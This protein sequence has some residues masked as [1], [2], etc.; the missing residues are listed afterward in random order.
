MK[1][2]SSLFGSSS[3]GSSAAVSNV[4]SSRLIRLPRC[5]SLGPSTACG[6]RS[7]YRRRPLSM[8]ISPFYSMGNS[9]RHSSS[10]AVSAS[11]F[12][13][14]GHVYGQAFRQRVKGM[15]ICESPDRAPQPVAEP[16]RGATH[17]LDPARVSGSRTRPWRTAPT[18]QPRR[19]S[20][21]RLKGW[22]CPIPS[23]G[24]SFPTE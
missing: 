14:K 20:Q 8:R 18:P 3:N 11:R 17:R 23:Y 7:S 9:L 21:N 2:S 15:G 19:I 12:H 10:R 13:L 6:A 16:L 22:R 5:L 1:R 4:T 24:L